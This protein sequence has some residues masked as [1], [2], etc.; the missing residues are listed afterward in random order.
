MNYSPLYG[1]EKAAWLHEELRDVPMKGQ[2]R[3][4]RITVLRGDKLAV[5]ELELGPQEDALPAPFNIASKVGNDRIEHWAYSVAEI[6]ELADRLREQKAPE[7]IERT[8]L[9]PAWFNE[10]DERMQWRRRRSVYGSL[11]N[12]QRN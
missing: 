12:I 3:F 7:Q 5:Y 11:I 6:R 10:L 1:D 4:Q 9:V 8:D 2:H